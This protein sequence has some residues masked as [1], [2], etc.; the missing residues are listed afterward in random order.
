VSPRLA[1][2]TI[3]I[4]IWDAFA[5][6]LGRSQGIR[7]FLG[8]SIRPMEYT[9]TRPRPLSPKSFR[10]HQSSSACTRPNSATHAEQERHDSHLS[11]TRGYK[12]SE[13]ETCL[14]SMTRE[15]LL[16]YSSVQFR[17]LFFHPEEGGSTFLE[18]MNGC[19]QETGGEVLYKQ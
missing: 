13:A 3:L 1:G 16:P 10:T 14:D 5:S 18:N 17:G 12:I 6:D 4:K 9:S 15:A 8:T 11:I 2:L 7:G 19:E